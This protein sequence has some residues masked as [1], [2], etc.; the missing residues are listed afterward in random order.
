[1][2]LRGLCLQGGHVY[3]RAVFARRAVRVCE[4][5]HS[6][7]V[8]DRQT[9]LEEEDVIDTDC[10]G[11]GTLEQSEGRNGRTIKIKEEKE[12]GREGE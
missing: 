11:G 10:F 4:R 2:S 5:A 3:E 12:Q 7:G 1:M 6:D 8:G 9:D